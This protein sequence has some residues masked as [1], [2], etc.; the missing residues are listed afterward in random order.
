MRESRRRQMENHCDRA[1]SIRANIGPNGRYELGKA[2]RSSSDHHNK[3]EAIKGHTIAIAAI[4]IVA[5]LTMGCGSP[6][7]DVRARIGAV[8]D[9]LPELHQICEQ[10]IEPTES[11]TR[12]LIAMGACPA[13]TLYRAPIAV[14]DMGEEQWTEIRELV[15]E[16]SA[17]HKECV[18]GGTQ[19]QISLQ[20][21]R[22]LASWTTDERINSWLEQ[23]HEALDL[24]E[25]GEMPRELAA[26]AEGNLAALENETQDAVWLAMNETTSFRYRT[27]PAGF[28]TDPEVAR[29][30]M[31]ELA[32]ELE[33]GA[34]RDEQQQRVHHGAER[35]H[36][37]TASGVA[38]SARQLVASIDRSHKKRNTAANSVARSQRSA[39]SKWLH[40]ARLYPTRPSN[41]RFP[42]GFEASELGA[43][44]KSNRTLV[45]V[46]HH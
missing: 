6:T 1:R 37:R 16:S 42:G 34:G 43:P 30:Q 32:E 12:T 23:M 36:R 40:I 8:A 39:S 41:P 18:A 45:L 29:N 13:P 22:A 27:L 31:A 2:A 5:V 25:S 28:T 38:C 46:T 24:I 3:G 26:E 10:A 17:A 21:V 35:A 15:A 33:A 44:W 7:R 14:L 4:G 20:T 11:A 19:A 9:G